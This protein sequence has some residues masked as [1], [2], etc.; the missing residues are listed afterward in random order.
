[1]E[2]KLPVRG[3]HLDGYNHVNNARYLEFLEEARWQYYDNISKEALQ[4]SDWAFVIVNI[5]IDY[6]FPA[7][8]G[9]YL[10]IHTEVDRVGGTSMTFQQNVFLNDTDTPVCSAKVTFVILDKKTGRPRS[11]EGELKQVL[12]KEISI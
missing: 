2:I 11:I 6:K 3:Y 10:R 9:D 8:L 5:N 1:M 12:L 4:T 7:T